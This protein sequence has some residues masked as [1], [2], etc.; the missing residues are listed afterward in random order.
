MSTQRVRPSKQYALVHPAIAI[1]VF[2]LG[3]YGLYGL[4]PIRQTPSPGG[5]GLVFNFAFVVL[6]ASSAWLAS[7]PIVSTPQ[8]PL[9]GH[10]REMPTGARLVALL[11]FIGC[12]GAVLGILSK[13][14]AA[15]LNALI[16]AASLRNERAQQLMDA[17]TITSGPAGALAFLTY[18]AGYVAVYVAMLRFEQLTSTARRLA[19]LFVPLAFT[20]S[21]VAG[22]RS[23]IV[24]LLILI[25][26]AAYVRRHRG[27]RAIPQSAAVKWLGRVLVILFLVYSSTIWFVRAELSDLTSDGFLTLA[28]ASWGVVPTPA[29]E[30]FATSTGQP[31]LLQ[32]MIS[33][34][35]YFTSSLSVTERVLSMVN[36]PTL[37]GGYHIDLAAGLLRTSPEGRQFLSDGYERLLDANVYG[38]FTG[39]WSALYI[40]FGALGAVAYTVIWG[41]LA[42][43]TF[44]AMTRFGSDADAAMYGFWFYSVLISFVSPPLGFSNSAITLCWFLA[45]VVAMRIRQIRQTRK[46]R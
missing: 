5:I 37:L 44:R 46:I 26:I 38:F 43:R 40:D 31:E 17:D 13:A 27:A 20:Q 6:F 30:A 28:D 15:P 19:L 42:G 33:T 7:I 29:L 2:W 12:V 21:V 11:A 18:P 4:A 9:S 45:F 10:R 16:D 25:S 41:L 14:G 22:G 32:I 23:G 35:F 34:I 36:V 8:D 1:V 3:L 39:A 24:V